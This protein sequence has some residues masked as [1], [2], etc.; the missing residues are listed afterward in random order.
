MPKLSDTQS[1]LLTAAAQRSDGNLLP[2]PGSL[3][4]GAASKVVGALLSRGFVEETV[5]D[6]TRSADAALN[7]PWRNLDDGRG[8]LLRITAAGLA[9]IGVERATAL[10]VTVGHASAAGLEPDSAPGGGS[11]A[12]LANDAPQ[13]SAMVQESPAPGP[14]AQTGKTREGTKQAQLIAMLKRPE[15]ATIEQIVAATGWQPHTVR[16]AFAGALK[17]R[18]GL[19]VASEKVQGGERVYR[20]AGEAGR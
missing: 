16:G 1:I 4:G 7:T 19:T 11:T 6:D 20:I 10:G 15:G 18:L 14:G 9:A 12:G 5:I 17:K 2:L 3:R 8:V 13:G